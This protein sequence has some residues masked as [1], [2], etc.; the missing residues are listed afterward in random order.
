M[1]RLAPEIEID[2]LAQDP[3]TRVLQSA[4][5]TIHPL[6]RALHSE[7]GLCER[8]AAEHEL[9]VFRA[10]REMQETFLANFMIFLEAVR[11]RP[12]DA[13]V[14]DE[15]WRYTQKLWMRVKRKAAYLPGC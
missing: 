9:H 12:Y 1:L 11:D 6:S 10:Y 7:S 5:E 8:L 4:G 13:W 2:W 15:A 14:G 3:V